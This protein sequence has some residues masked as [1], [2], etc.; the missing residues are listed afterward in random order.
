MDNNTKKCEATC[1]NGFAESTSRYCVAR[2]F[3][4]PDTYGHIDSNGVKTC[5]YK[6]LSIT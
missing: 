4:A 1:T 2:C 3:G 6:C 5:K